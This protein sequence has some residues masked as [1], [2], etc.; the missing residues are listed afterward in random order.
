MNEVSC[1]SQGLTKYRW[2]ASPADVE[3]LAQVCHE[4]NRA[5]CGTLGE[6]GQLPWDEAP[7]W[8]KESARRGVE[9]H[10]RSDNVG[11]EESHNSWME[12][13][14]R[15]G[16]RYGEVKDAEAKVHPCLLPYK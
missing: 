7:D 16:W 4:A 9:L 5:Y 14:L 6:V 2:E 11:P 15:E 10:L 13:K 12:Q 1:L 8:Q 3:V